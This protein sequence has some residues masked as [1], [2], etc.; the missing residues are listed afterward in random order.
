MLVHRQSRVPSRCVVLFVRSFHPLLL[1]S[2]SHKAAVR[3]TRNKL[4]HARGNINVI[5]QMGNRIRDICQNLW[6]RG[7]NYN[8]K[9]S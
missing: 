7:Y 3:L 2:S 4:T 8:Q 6:K 9:R 5:Y 1:A